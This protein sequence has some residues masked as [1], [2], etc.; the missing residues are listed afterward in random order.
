[1]KSASFWLYNLVSPASGDAPN[2]GANDGALLLRL[3]NASYRDFRPTV[4]LSMAVFCNEN[5]YIGKG[6]FT[7]QLE[8]LSVKP[9]TK[10]ADTYTS[11]VFDNGG[12]A[13]LRHNETMLLLRYPRFKYR[14]SQADIFHIDLWRAGE[15]ILCDAGTYSYNADPDMSWYFSGSPGHNTVEF[16]CRDQMPK[17]SRFLYG[18]WLKTEFIS[19]IFQEDD[20]IC[21]SGC[22]VDFKKAKHRREVKL[23]GKSLKVVD[24]VSGFK[25]KAV[26]RWRLSEGGWEIRK[27]N[28]SI[29]LTNG[30][31]TMVIKSDVPIARAELVKGWKSLFY[32]YKS[33][34]DVIEVEVETDGQFLTE[35]RWSD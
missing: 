27:E 9:G 14:P 4:Q 32:M 23:S 22:Y 28:G 10:Q 19:S 17:L 18:G 11:Q 6:S 21:I 12:Y 2:V 5:A 35:Y 13:V 16:D 26:L 20:S 25:T 33:P 24:K 3:T 15:N 31:D 29:L 30:K 8:W 1:M 7:D 34:I